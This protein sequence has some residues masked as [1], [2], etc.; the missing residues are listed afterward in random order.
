MRALCSSTQSPMGAMRPDSSA[1]SRKAAGARSPR[2]GWF[3]RKRASAATTRPVCADS[4][5]WKRTPN[6]SAASAC[7]NS[8][9]NC[10]RSRAAVRISSLNNSERPR[11]RCLARY[12]AVSADR[13]SVIAASAAD[14]EARSSGVD[15]ATPTLAPASISTPCSTSG[16]VIEVRMRSAT[17]S[18]TCSSSNPSQ[19]TTNSSP[20]IRATR[21]LGR[22]AAA[23]RRDTETISWSPT[24]WPMVSLT[25]L[26]LSRSI[27]RTA[28]VACVVLLRSSA[29]VVLRTKSTRLGKPVSA[30]WVACRA[31]S[32]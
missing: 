18:A 21:S 7:S 29:S 5:G 23:S 13:R 14:S 10:R 30:S 4:M 20:L 17:S 32:D 8:D 1:R 31:S 22:V 9:D 25:C 11:P 3:H 2:V 6:C 12:I 24:A 26:S 28:T 15:I 27:K 19:R 16:P